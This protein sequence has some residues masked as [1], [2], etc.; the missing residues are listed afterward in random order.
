MV[1]IE[2][3]VREE[4]R[5]FQLVNNEGGRAGCQDDWQEFNIMRTSQFM[6]WPEEI[7]RSYYSDLMQAKASGRNLL[8]EKYAFMMRETAPDRYVMVKGALPELSARKVQLIERIVEI[9]VRWAEEFQ[10][11]Y[12][13]YAKRGRVIRAKDAQIGETSI[14]T[15]QRGELSSYGEQTV[16]LYAAYVDECVAKEINLTETVR[17]YMAH[18]HGYESKEDVERSVG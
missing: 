13:N 5:Q 8:F 14:E 15:Y 6:A 7:L 17:E 12:P 2:D 3:V 4:W 10:E 11:R 16:E 9:Q 1:S 18:M